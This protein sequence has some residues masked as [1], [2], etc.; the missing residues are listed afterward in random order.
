MMRGSCLCKAITFTVNGDIRNARYCHC[1]NCRKFSG[2]S[3][4]PWA[5]TETAKLKMT[6]TDA[7]VSKF[8]SGRGLRCF[9]SDCGSPVWFE[10]LKYPEIIAIPLGVL[11]D[12]GI[13]APEMHIWTQSQPAWSSIDDDLPQYKTNPPT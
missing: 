1:K 2:A 10:S 4:A 8:N 11:D 13:P 3:A 7:N 9:C 12:E 6:S 5:I